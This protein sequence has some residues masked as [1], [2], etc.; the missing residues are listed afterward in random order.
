MKLFRSIRK[1]LLEEN[2]ISKYLRYAGGEI[3]LVVI[4][5]LL[6]LQINTWKENANNK[7]I[8]RA[9]LSGILNNLDQDI[10]ELDK[11]VDEDTLN[12]RNYTLMLNSFTDKTIN[13][14]SKQFI[15]AIGQAYV[16]HSFTGNSI[17][18]E[19]MKS[20][21]KINFIKSDVLR[22]SILEYYNSS[23][24]EIVRQNNLH[25]PNMHKLRDEAFHDNIDMNSLIEK[26]LYLDQHSAE[27][28]PLDL[29]FF[30]SDPNSDDVMKF[31]NRISLMKVQ[32]ETNGF[33]NSELV[34]KAH[35][36]KRKIK[37]YL[38]SDNVD[39]KAYI[40]T[41]I[42]TA[43][44]EGDTEK[45]R[46][47]IPTESLNN[48]LET[49]NETRNYLVV[50]IHENSLESLKYFVESGADL[51][52]V[53]E[54]KTPLMYASKYGNESITKYLISVGANLDF[55]SIKGK[56]ALDYAIQYEQKNLIEYLKSLNAKQVMTLEKD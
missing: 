43:I 36:L 51:N 53:C 30:D 11:L 49:K 1:K 21:G 25:I 24:R 42:R 28:N 16:S 13:T 31:A 9:Y 40:S 39:G 47:L 18:F 8:E 35:R 52:K 34:L 55:V 26:F 19:D 50:A 32:V 14:Y 33:H 48:C 44:K 45:L 4:G 27:I 3:I 29:S 10:Y 6:A 41:E 38:D 22:F 5:I 7:D 15:K 46:L 2:K 56:T 12:L 37:E 17:V 23:Q 20:S 54:N